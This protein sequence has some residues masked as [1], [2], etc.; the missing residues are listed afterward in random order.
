MW[1]DIESLSHAARLSPARAEG[2]LHTDETGADRPCGLARATGDRG[3]GDVLRIEPVS[4]D[5]WL[6][7]AGLA[8]GLVAVM[9]IFKALRPRPRRRRA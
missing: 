8:L 3:L 2:S 7:V 9:E 1:Q 6:S 5:A 4:L